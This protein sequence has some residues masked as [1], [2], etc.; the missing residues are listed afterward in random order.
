MLYPGEA[1]F[2]YD[3]ASDPTSHIKDSVWALYARAQLLWLACLRMRQLPRTS[4]DMPFH[5]GDDLDEAGL[6]SLSSVSNRYESRPIA[7]S[8]AEFADFTIKAWLQTREIEEAL[9]A[10]TCNLE[11][12][13][14]FHG[15]E[16]LST[17]DPVVSQALS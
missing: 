1:A 6:Y 8:E 13:Y 16:Y 4:T 7:I 5:S 11:R 2:Y 14:L 3:Q 15:R 10:H 9:D 12:A 17:C